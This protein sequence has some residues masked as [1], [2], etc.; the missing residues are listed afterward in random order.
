MKSAALAAISGGIALAL[1]ERSR[2]T[3]RRHRDPCHARAIDELPATDKCAK[4]DG[5]PR[6][7]T[8]HAFRCHVERQCRAQCARGRLSP[9]GEN[10][11]AGFG[12]ACFP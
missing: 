7:P 4:V 1:T 5:M 9:E 6:C 11:A 10:D 2:N 12:A 3:P 8:R